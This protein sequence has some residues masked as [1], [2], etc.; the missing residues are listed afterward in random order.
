VLTGASFANEAAVDP[1]LRHVFP[2]A[3]P[4]RDVLASNPWV[5]TLTL[6][7]G[8]VSAVG[9]HVATRVAATQFQ[10]A[11]AM[12]IVQAGLTIGT[13]ASPMANH[14]SRR[15][16]ITTA[17]L[18]IP[19]AIAGGAIYQSRKSDERLEQTSASI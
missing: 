11:A 4:G 16:W 15:Q 12:G 17:I 6:A 2:Q 8:F 3:L 1:L 10:H 7:Y 19:A 9:G 13:M 14:D 18:T 5:G